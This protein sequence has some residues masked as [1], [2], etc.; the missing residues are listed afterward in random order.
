MKKAICAMLALAM[1]LVCASAESL[2]DKFDMA[3]R[4]KSQ[5]NLYLVEKDGLWGIADG[6]GGTV[7]APQF[8]IVGDFEDGSAT[9]YRDGKWGL[10][11]DTGEVLLKPTLRFEPQFMN[12]VAVAG[13]E[14]PSRPTG[15]ISSNDGE[16]EVV[17]GVINRVGEIVIPIKYECV[18][19]DDVGETFMVMEDGLYG[20]LNGKGEW[21][22]EP[23]YARANPFVDG[24]AAVSIR[25]MRVANENVS[26]P[27]YYVWGVIDKTGKELI[28]LQYMWVE[29]G[30]GDIVIVGND[31]YHYGYM[32]LTG[33][34]VVEPKFN[35]AELFE[36]GTAI[37]SIEKETGE[38]Q[39]SGET[40][41]YLYGVVGEDGEEI[42]PFEYSYIYR[43]NDG[44]LDCEKN[45]MRTFYRIEDGK[46]VAIEE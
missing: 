39:C 15:G 16:Y 14:D 19:Q 40:S 36:G 38:D 44:T 6:D 3:G 32:D 12:G 7:L 8:E 24:H 31:G 4:I 42:L 35:H 9:A 37:A 25:N 27:F 18:E 11:S 17:Y 23:K 29:S 34:W 22:I 1:I 46:A 43:A 26:D 21:V 10:I 20:Y 30:A 2:L 5:E 13:K 41:V 28:P 45:G 33:K